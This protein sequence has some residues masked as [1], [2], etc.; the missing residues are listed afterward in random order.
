MNK[1][2]LI[3]AIVIPLIIFGL[4]LTY[5]SE[6]KKTYYKK[7]VD[8]VVNQVNEKTNFEIKKQEKK[9][10]VLLEQDYKD[11]VTTEVIKTVTETKIQKVIEYVDKYIE[12]PVGCEQLASDTVWMLSETTDIINSAARSRN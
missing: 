8:S 1:F 2:K 9:N 5:I 4:F 6:V 7:G 11:T 10:F 3:A 12:V